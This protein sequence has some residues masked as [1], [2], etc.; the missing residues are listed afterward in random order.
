MS[1][2]R[3][4]ADRR[5]RVLYT[6]GVAENE[7]STAASR[8]NALL[9]R[10]ARNPA[11]AYGSRVQRRLRGRW[12]SLVP[13]HRRTFVAVA[14]MLWT[15]ASL[16]VFMHY[17]SVS[18]PSLA[19]QPDIARP[20][21]LDRPDSFGAWLTTLLLAASAGASLLIYQL[22]RYRI[23]DFKGHYRLWRLVIIVCGLAS[24]NSL[25][26][27]V[28][29]AGA[30][31]DAGF[32]RRVAL[33]GNDWL[34]IVMAVA[35]VVLAMRLIAEVRRSRWALMTMIAGWSLLA[36]PVAA[37]W[38]F[39]AVESLN[40]WVVVTASEL[41]GITTLFISL[42]G[43][44]R[45]LYREVRRVEDGESI[46]RRWQLF[47]DR[48]FHRDVDDESMPEK[49]PPKRSR[50]EPT[51]ASEQPSTKVESASQSKIETPREPR[52][53]F[54]LRAAKP[55]TAA[56]PATAAKVTAEAKPAPSSPAPSSPAPSNPL[57][58]TAAVSKPQVTATVPA[59]QES[60]SS[61]K[62]KRF[63]LGMFTKRR[64][65][66]AEQKAGASG[67]ST[68]VSLAN[69]SDA[70]SD[71]DNENFGDDDNVDYS[72][73]SKAERRRLRKQQRRGNAA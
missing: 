59:V 71:S 43:Y 4:S 28:D 17:A 18:W 22:R 67:P 15:M 51:K 24:V 6:S 2:S 13:V 25:V 53:W 38:N 32:G 45:M 19:N 29:W 56:K 36:I 20:L 44:L 27:V 34:H 16:L 21:R 64:G 62:P 58:S 23:D 35:G 12:F 42:G 72:G 60:I 49:L 41:L 11:A 8:R 37:K 26:A 47:R 30:L 50:R 33:S 3:R 52:R 63:G 7:V 65:A 10:E 54:G 5:R 69:S 68:P 39:M 66:E 57:P 1:Y 46:A 48:V 40:A 14:A 31:L 9:L 61:E 55:T 73:M 70:E